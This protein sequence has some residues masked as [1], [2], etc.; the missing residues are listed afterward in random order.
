MNSAGVI[1]SHGEFSMLGR[2]QAADMAV[3]GH[4]VGRVGEDHLGPL[5]AQQAGIGYP[6]A[7]AQGWTGGTI[8]ASDQIHNCILAVYQAQR[9]A[10]TILLAEYL[11][12]EGPG[13]DHVN[14]ALVQIQRPEWGSWQ[15]LLGKLND[16][17]ARKDKADRRFPSLM[18]GYAAL[19]AEGRKDCVLPPGLAAAVGQVKAASR[20]HFQAAGRGAGQDSRTDKVIQALRNARAHFGAGAT[21]DEETARQDEALV[22]AVRLVASHVCR[23]LLPPGSVIVQARLTPPDDQAPAGDDVVTL[24]G[25]DLER[26]QRT[27]V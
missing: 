9:L 21:R 23:T 10:A 2:P 3:D 16:Y 22:P 5:F 19:K 26:I 14:N 27:V 12:E 13:D 17:F 25:Y 15:T 6:L 11:L 18:D 1:S 20:F 24:A 8:T 7:V 4:I